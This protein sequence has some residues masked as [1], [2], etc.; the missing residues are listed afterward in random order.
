MKV[1]KKLLYIAMANACLDTADL[2]KKSSLPRPTLNNAI[3]GKTVRPKTIGSIA[4]ALGVR[5]EDILLKEE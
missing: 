5:V 3:V 1:D 4:K 2:Q